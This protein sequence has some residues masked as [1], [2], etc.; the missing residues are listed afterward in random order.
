MLDKMQT[1]KGEGQTL[2]VKNMNG[3]SSGQHL[4]NLGIYTNGSSDP[5][6][7]GQANGGQGTAGGAGTVNAGDSV[8][9]KSMRNSE[10]VSHSDTILDMAIV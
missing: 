9:E 5:S 6:G 7:T 1:E 2:L 8:T 10:I 4:N 3:L